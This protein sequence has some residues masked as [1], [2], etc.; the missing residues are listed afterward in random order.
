M[1]RS[2]DP[3]ELASV[4]H[5]LE[6]LQIVAQPAA[7]GWLP[8]APDA[9]RLP[10]TSGDQVPTAGRRWRAT[11]RGNVSARPHVSAF[12]P[13]RRGVVVLVLVVVSVVSV[14]RG[15]GQHDPSASVLKA[16]STIAGRVSRTDQDGDIAISVT[17]GG[18]KVVTRR[19]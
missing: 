14:G 17:C 19:T 15:N 2:P 3:R 9:E 11:L 8:H 5:R 1:R 13:G 7:A 10:P 16:L 6:G 18:L 4:L 12:D